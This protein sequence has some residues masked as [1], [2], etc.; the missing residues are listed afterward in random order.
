VGF[1]VIIN[2]TPLIN[3]ERLHLLFVATLF[4]PFVLTHV[5]FF[6]ILEIS[7]LLYFSYYYIIPLFTVPPVLEVSHLHP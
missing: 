1:R 5:Q 7:I 2:A 6:S 3:I 4:G